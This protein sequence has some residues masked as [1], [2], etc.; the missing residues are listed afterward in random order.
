MHYAVRAMGW[1]SV[2]LVM[3]VGIA[4]LSVF[5]IV[6]ADN[7][8]TQQ[9]D[10]LRLESRMTQLEQ[11]LYTIENSV[12]SVEQQARLGSVS[13]RTVSQDELNLLRSQLQTLERRL[14][15]DECGLARIDERTLSPQRREARKRSA[16]ADPDQCRQN[17][18]APLRLP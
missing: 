8:G 4:A 2:V 6:R 3:L 5:R 16:S 15:E 10:V 13:S 1:R 11:R 14:G 12:R 9:Q 18:D 7:E 17:P